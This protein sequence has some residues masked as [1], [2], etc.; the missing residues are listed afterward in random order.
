MARNCERC[1]KTRPAADG[2]IMR[3]R[4]CGVLPV[5]DK[6]AIFGHRVDRDLFEALT[7]TDG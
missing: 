5:V 3:Y 2:E 1:V 6:T 7:R 4:R